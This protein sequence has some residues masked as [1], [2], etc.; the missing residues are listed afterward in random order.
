VKIGV[1]SLQ[2]DFI[3]HRKMLESLSVDVVLV[4]YDHDL[5]DIN[6]LILPG[7]ESTTIGK[8]L[9]KFKL[10]DLIKEKIKSGMPVFGTCAGMILLAR[11]INNADQP[12][13]RLLDIEVERNGYGSQIES[14]EADLLLKIPEKKKI[15]GVFIRAPLIKNTGKNVKILS[16]FNEAPV[17]VLENNILAANFH[18]ELTENNSL[19]KYFLS[20]CRDAS[21]S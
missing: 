13:L 21:M 7:G 15:R 12:G 9:I 6:G 2:G 4:K 3:K 11:N 18:P 8:L 5:K 10:M 20:I 17:V 19:H 14:F 16:T 1:L